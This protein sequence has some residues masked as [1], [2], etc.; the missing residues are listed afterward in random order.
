MRKTLAYLGLF[1]INLF[2][3]L[4]G[5]AQTTTITGNVHNS[6]TKEVVPAASVLIKGATTGTFTDNKGN[7]D[8]SRA[9][10]CQ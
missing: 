7:F 2:M 9:R 8:W 5:S 3:V 1:L 4:S 10:N 6:A